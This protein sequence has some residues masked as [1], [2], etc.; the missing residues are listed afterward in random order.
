[1]SELILLEKDNWKVRYTMIDGQPHF[2]AAD[3]ATA[4]GYSWQ[5][6]VV[7]HVPDKFKGINPINTPGG[8]QKMLT[9]TEAGMNFFVIRSDKAAA[10]PFQEWISSEVLP[11]IRKTGKYLTPDAIARA[12]EGTE[13]P[14]PAGEAELIK[15]RASQDRA[16]AMLLNA[17]TRAYKALM[18]SINDKGLSPVAV[19]L[20]GLNAIE[21][22]TGQHVDYRPEIGKTYTCT[23]IAAEMG[24]PPQTLGRIATQHNIKTAEYGITVLDKSPYSNKQ[25]AVFRYNEKGRAKLHE[26][27]GNQRRPC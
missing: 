7:S 24:I 14:L 12:Y 15:A 20:F 2:V 13:Q 22:I 5:P 10:L 25:V 23:E 17:R 26:L 11:S 1:M 19:Q 6:N 4:L 27:F 18:N 16:A 9:L 3:I 21:S 8:I